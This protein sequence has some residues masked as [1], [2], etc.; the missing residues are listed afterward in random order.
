[1]NIIEIKK[2][3]TILEERLVAYSHKD[4][5]AAALY[6]D[7]KPL[8]ELAKSGK[9][10][11]PLE[12]GSVPGRFRFTEKNLQ[13]YDDLEEA[14]AKFSIEITGGETLALKLFRQSM[15]RENNE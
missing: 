6:S 11:H 13:Q 4:P 8:L 3:A 9:I 2:T 12:T 15:Q 7:L 14:Y 5:E 10:T 1:M